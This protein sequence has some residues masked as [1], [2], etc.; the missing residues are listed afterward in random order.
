MLRRVKIVSSFRDP[1]LFVLLL[2]PL[3]HVIGC[4]DVRQ[5]IHFGAPVDIALYIQETSRDG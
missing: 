4:P 1:F 2:L 3:D 5:V